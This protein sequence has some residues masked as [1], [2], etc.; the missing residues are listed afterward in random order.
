[1][2]SARDTL[3]F[4]LPFARRLTQQTYATT[5]LPKKISHQR[6]DLRHRR[7][8]RTNQRKSRCLPAQSSGELGVWIQYSY[9]PL[10]E[11]I[12]S[13]TEDSARP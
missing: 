7:S 5:D 9:C 1:M 4:F 10:M 8:K 11:E 2:L 13:F 3:D 12:R 6:T